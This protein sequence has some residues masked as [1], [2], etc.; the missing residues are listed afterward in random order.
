M[1]TIDVQATL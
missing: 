1:G